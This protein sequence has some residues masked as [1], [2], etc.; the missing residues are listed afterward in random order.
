MVTVALPSDCGTTT[1][2]LK[3]LVVSTT[4]LSVWT[5]TE[6]PTRDDACSAWDDLKLPE[7]AVTVSLSVVMP[8]RLLNCAN[9]ATNSLLS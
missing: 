6:R 5:T 8:S 3:L 9:W 4:A 7:I 2:P 1:E